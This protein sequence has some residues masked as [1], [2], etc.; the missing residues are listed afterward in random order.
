MLFRQSLI[1]NLVVPTGLLLVFAGPTPSFA[2]TASGSVG[3]VGVSFVDT[4]IT[5]E[6]D[7]VAACSDQDVY[8]PFNGRYCADS[9]K[10]LSPLSYEGWAFSHGEQVSP[11]QFPDGNFYFPMNRLYSVKHNDHFDYEV[12][13]KKID[14]KYYWFAP[15]EWLGKG[16]YLPGWKVID[17]WIWQSGH[18]QSGHS[19]NYVSNEH[20]PLDAEWRYFGPGLNNGVCAP[21][22]GAAFVDGWH[23]VPY[24][25]NVGL[26]YMPSGMYYFNEQGVWQRD[27]FTDVDSTTPHSEDIK[28]LARQGIT[29]GYNDGSFQGM[30]PV[31]RQDMAAFLY[32]LAGSPS[33]EAPSQSPFVDVNE[34]TPHYKEI[35]WLAQTG[36]STGWKVSSGN[37]FRGMD[38]VKRQDM[39]AFLKRLSD[40]LNKG[41]VSSSSNPFSDVNES[42]PHYEEV[43][44]LSENGVSEG[45]AEANG[46]R[47]FRGMSDVVRQDMA[48]FLHRMDANGLV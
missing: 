18:S 38:S 7:S 5:P 1:K 44:W 11:D 41:G 26:D 29:R 40:Y 3:G 24:D 8:D 48:A 13:L 9:G 34:N 31:Y 45:W 21:E 30:T 23:Y 32:R 15:S 6:S 42:T 12:G 35:C 10:P 43:L 17:T 14:G 19:Y 28:W 22:G 47:T 39:A 2:M 33:F 27:V 46:S 20:A 36:I 16:N 4:G 25:I 37:E